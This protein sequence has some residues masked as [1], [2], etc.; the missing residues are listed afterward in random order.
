MMG[1]CT[2]DGLMIFCHLLNLPYM[3]YLPFFAPLTRAIFV[4]LFLRTLGLHLWPMFVLALQQSAA[5]ADEALLQLVKQLS[6]NLNPTSIKLGWARQTQPP[7]THMPRHTCHSTC[8][9]TAWQGTVRCG[10]A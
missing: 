3:C 4:V 1:A 6:D 8:H 2:D 7:I 9:S 5:M 10:A